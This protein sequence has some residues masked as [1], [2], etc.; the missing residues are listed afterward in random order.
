[1]RTSFRRY[2]FSALFLEGVSVVSCTLVELKHGASS[3]GGP[4]SSPL[5]VL[6]LIGLVLFVAL[7][8]GVEAVGS[9]L[10]RAVSPFNLDVGTVAIILRGILPLLL[11]LLLLQ[12][13]GEQA[14]SGRCLDGRASAVHADPEILLRQDSPG[15]HVVL[16]TA[17]LHPY[18]LLLALDGREELGDADARGAPA[19]ADLD[20]DVGMEEARAALDGL[21]AVLWG[22]HREILLLDVDVSAGAEAPAFFPG[23]VAA[24]EAPV[25]LGDEFDAH[26]GLQNCAGCL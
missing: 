20:G 17:A 14:G 19:Q 10:L 9:G 1:M 13:Q 18:G 24:E 12:G 22:R 21:F 15:P 5:L 4:F 23:D 26:G 16:A 25:A 2:S 7:T 6:V 3:V 8:H 11:L